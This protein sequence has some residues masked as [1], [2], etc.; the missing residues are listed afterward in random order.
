MATTKLIEELNTSNPHEVEEWLD[1]F[2]SMVEVN[3]VYLN[4]DTDDLRNQR[5]RSLLVSVIAP[6][7]YKLLKAYAAP[8][9]PREMT[10]AQLKTLIQTNLCPKPSAISEAYQH[11]HHHFC[12]SSQESYGA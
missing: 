1:R 6:E 4:A 9:T 10:F 7:G 8:N 2:E 3:S 5:K 11:Q 12:G